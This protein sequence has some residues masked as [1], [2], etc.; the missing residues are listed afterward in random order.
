M[1]LSI[2]NGYVTFQWEDG[3]T[4]VLTIKEYEKF[5]KAQDKL[6]R[7]SK[8]KKPTPPKK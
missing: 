3:E 6:N 4:I 2:K 7:C 1:V 8:P 5:M